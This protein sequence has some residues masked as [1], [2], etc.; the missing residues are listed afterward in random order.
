[1][2]I[3]CLLW[4]STCTRFCLSRNPYYGRFVCRFWKIHFLM[5][6]HWLEISFSGFPHWF[7]GKTRCGHFGAQLG[8]VSEYQSRLNILISFSFWCLIKRKC[9][10]DSVMIVHVWKGISP[11]GVLGNIYI[12]IIVYLYIVAGRCRKISAAK[13]VAMIKNQGLALVTL[14]TQ[15]LT[16]PRT[17]KVERCWTSAI[18]AAQAAWLICLADEFLKVCHLIDTVFGTSDTLTFWLINVARSHPFLI[19]LISCRMYFHELFFFAEIL[20]IF[21]TFH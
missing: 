7:Q 14:R 21:G 10:M 15:L 9:I 17:N 2:L 12:C 13:I 8:W 18:K 11:V 19:S 6:L 4:T 3:L 1:M 20:R 16:H 5:A